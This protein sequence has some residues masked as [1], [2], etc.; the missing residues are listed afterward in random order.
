MYDVPLH[1]DAV[2]VAALP[3]SFID[4]TAPALATIDVARQRVRSEPGWRV[5]EI[6]T[7]DDAMVS[8]PG[9]LLHVLLDLA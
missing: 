9:A 6:A 4:C 7:G 5:V 1:F 2:R 3:Q 8:A